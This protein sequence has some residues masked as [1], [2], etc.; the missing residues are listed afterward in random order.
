VLA[1]GKKFFVGRLNPSYWT[2]QEYSDIE[3]EDKKR[4]E[5]RTT[6]AVVLDIPSVLRH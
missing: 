6:N 2:S 1:F 5:S 4:R 3:V